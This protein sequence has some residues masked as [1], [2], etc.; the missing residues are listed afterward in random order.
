M[1]QPVMILPDVILTVYKRAYRVG[2]G[3]QWQGGVLWL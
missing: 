1:D 3:V 2:S